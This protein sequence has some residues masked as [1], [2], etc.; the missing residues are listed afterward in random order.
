MLGKEQW[1]KGQNTEY[2][3][4]LDKR[5]AGMRHSIQK[6]DNICDGDL[7]CTSC[8]IFVESDP[9]NW[10]GYECRYGRCPKCGGYLESVRKS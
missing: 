5:Y 10:H 9:I 4:M 3:K 8:D 6:A 2:V 7:D 1:V